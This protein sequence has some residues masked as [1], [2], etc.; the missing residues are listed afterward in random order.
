MRHMI[1]AVTVELVKSAGRCVTAE[2]LAEKLF[3]R[4]ILV[5]SALEAL[6]SEGAGVEQAEGCFRVR[7]PVELAIAAAKLGVSEIELAKG[8]DWRMFEEFAAR[9][10]REAGYTVYRNLKAYSPVGLEVDV[11]GLRPNH[12]VA[13]DCK[14]WDPRYSSPSRL[15]AAALRH[16]KR[17]DRLALLWRKLGLPR[18]KWIVVPA[19]L[20]LRRSVDRIMEG[21]AV[22]PVSN[23]RGF[24]EE[25]S[26][27]AYSGLLRT[28]VVE[29]L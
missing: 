2:E 3:A 21:V 19:L 25:L 23:L 9:A 12:A 18:G 11:L 17:V 4:P 8:L 22:V 5:R 28:K 24:I 1:A 27:L 6:A 10:L 26:S 16:L 14:H 13:L 7:D 15:R 20:V 29:T